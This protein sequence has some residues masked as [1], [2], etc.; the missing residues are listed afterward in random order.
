MMGENDNQSLQTSDGH[1]QTQIG[2]YHWPPAYE[3][4]VR[5]F[6]KIAINAGAHVVWVGLPIVS[7]PKRWEVIR[8]QN[9]LFAQ[10]AEK[11]PNMA[12]VDTWDM[13]ATPDGKYSKYLRTGN[14]TV[15]PVRADDGVHFLTSGYL[16]IARAAMQA[17]TQ[18][19]DLAPKVSRP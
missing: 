16:M 8:R 17:A 1:L 15:V 2:T 10:V 5:E 14:G 6:A 9:E 13:F 7:D 11:T 3:D 19:F 12:F 4:R 18:Q